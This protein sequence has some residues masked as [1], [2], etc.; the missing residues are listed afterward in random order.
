MNDKIHIGELIRS[1]L[2]EKERSVTWLAKKV[3]HDPSSLCKL[4]KRNNID[5]ELLLQ[6][7][8][9]LNYDFFVYYSDFIK[10]YN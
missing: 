7:S 3:Y 1:K 2:E 9:I 5:T 10:H 8:L 4:L 6:I